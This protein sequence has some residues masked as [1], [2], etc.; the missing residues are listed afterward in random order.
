MK[1]RTGSAQVRKKRA[2]SEAGLPICPQGLNCPYIDEFQHRTEFSHDL[3]KE[4]TIT[5]STFQ[6]FASSGRR[7][8]GSLHAPSVLL[9]EY[10]GQKN[11]QGETKRSRA[12]PSSS[13]SIESSSNVRHDPYDHFSSTIIS[14]EYPSGVGT[15]VPA[16]QYSDI[17]VVVCGICGSSVAIAEL[18]S[19]MISHDRQDQSR[20]LRKQQDE[21]YAD[22]VLT[23]VLHRSAEEHRLHEEERNTKKQEIEKAEAIAREESLREQERRAMLWAQANLVPE[24]SAS[25]GP[26]TSIRFV[27]PSGERITRRFQATDSVQRCFD[28]LAAQE[29]LCHLRYRLRPMLGGDE[30]EAPVASNKT[31]ISERL[32]PNSAL[33]LVMIDKD[34]AVNP[35]EHVPTTLPSRHH[36]QDNNYIKEIDIT[37]PP[38]RKG[39]VVVDLTLT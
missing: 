26:V 20:M 3:S 27:F 17:D 38:A 32:H 12:I 14:R 2:R 25:E 6:P 13:K 23:D 31:F 28:F 34:D 9:A 8:G 36:C 33:A 4:T 29:S 24:P 10:N 22:S 39:A 18:D 5:S 11:G 35:A 30:F 19:H 1:S 21:E 7:L 37:T 16:A 15:S